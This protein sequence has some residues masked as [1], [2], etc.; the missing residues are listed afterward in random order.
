MQITFNLPNVFYP[1]ADRA[2]NSAELKGLLD[3]LIGSNMR[4]LTS[5]SFRKRPVPSLYRSR[6]RYGRTTWWENIPA[7]YRRGY[8]DCKSL[9]A[10]LIAEYRLSGIQCE[11]VHRFFNGQNGA[12]NY[13]ILVQVDGKTGFE[14][15]SKVL[16]M[17]KNENAHF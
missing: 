1:G 8:G 12:T 10:A 2:E 11:P 15:P 17:G 16:G 4:Y 13:H 6:V 14:D 3:Y 9:T 5:N 7:L